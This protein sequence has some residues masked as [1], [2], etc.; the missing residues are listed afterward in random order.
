MGGRGLN[1][2]ILSGEVECTVKNQPGDNVTIN[3]C[4]RQCMLKIRIVIKIISILASD[5]ELAGVTKNPFHECNIR[6]STR[7]QCPTISKIVGQLLV[8]INTL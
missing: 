6:P 3:Q 7:R 4:R 1:L 8:L 5:F 2:V